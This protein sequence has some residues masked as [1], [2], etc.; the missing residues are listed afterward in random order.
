MHVLV[1]RPRPEPL[2][3]TRR[4]AQKKIPNRKLRRETLRERALRPHR[5]LEM[6]E[7]ALRDEQ[8]VRQIEK[9]R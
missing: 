9:G 2:E 5:S 3:R 1:A 7:P 4:V 8:D 6:I